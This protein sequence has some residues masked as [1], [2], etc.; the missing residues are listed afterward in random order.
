VKEVTLTIDSREVRV[1]EG[2]TIL[3]AAEEAGIYIPALCNYPGL[4]PLT[5]LVASAWL[6]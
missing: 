1:E 5:K 6:R 3:K 2:T 4:K